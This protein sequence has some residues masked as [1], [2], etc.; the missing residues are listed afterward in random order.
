MEN[1]NFEQI[2]LTIIDQEEL[3]I[4]SIIAQEALKRKPHIEL[5]FREFD[6]LGCDS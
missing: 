6:K 3:T 2:L 1:L 5:F 4:R